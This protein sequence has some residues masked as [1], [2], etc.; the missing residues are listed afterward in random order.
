[1]F[2]LISVWLLWVHVSG[3]AH[4]KTLAMLQASVLG[5][6]AVNY[7]CDV[8]FFLVKL[9]PAAS[10]PWITAPVAFFALIDGLAAIWVVRSSRSIHQE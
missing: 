8:I 5:L 10:T 4:G 1:M 2:A 9:A 7:L 3:T 6:H